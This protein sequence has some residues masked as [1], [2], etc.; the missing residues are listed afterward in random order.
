M[1]FYPFFLPSLLFL[2]NT[3]QPGTVL[4]E[5]G[6]LEYLLR[7]AAVTLGAQSR[8]MTFKKLFVWDLRLT[9]VHTKLY[10]HLHFMLIWK[11]RQVHLQLAK[12][13]FQWKV[14]GN[15]SKV[16]SVICL[17]LIPFFS[18][19]TPYSHGSLCPTSCF[20][21][22]YSVLCRSMQSFSIFIDLECC[23]ANK[24]CMFLVLTE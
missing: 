20:S 3:E 21:D 18:Q 11:G 9:F 24:L 12:A 13:H 2:S 10:V 23:F 17:L 14:V 8:R 19:P 1:G 6:S 16:S 7:L 15:N 4:P 5:H 22:S